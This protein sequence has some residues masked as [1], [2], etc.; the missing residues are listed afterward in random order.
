V[1]KRSA[2]RDGNVP[3]SAELAADDVARDV[4]LAEVDR[5]VAEIE[6]IDAALDR[7]DSGTYGACID[8]GAAI[9]PAR[10]ARSPEV[11]RCLPCQQRKEQKAAARIARL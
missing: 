4:S 11:P 1:A 9:E 5:D 3:D 7:L 10:L 6:A 2:E 8:C